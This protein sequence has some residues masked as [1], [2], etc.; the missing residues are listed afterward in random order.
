MKSGVNELNWYEGLIGFGEEMQILPHDVL[1]KVWQVV[2][3]ERALKQESKV[4]E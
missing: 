4:C 2:S 1:S 3:A